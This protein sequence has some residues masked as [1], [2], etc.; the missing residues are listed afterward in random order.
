MPI[1]QHFVDELINVRQIQHG[2]GRGA[3]PIQN[4][5]RVG[6]SINRSCIVMLSA[7]LQAH[8]EEVFQG[9]VRR[10]FP[11]FVADPVAFDRYWK[12][13]KNWGNP[14][15]GN[16][17]I[18]FLKLGVPDIL[19]GLSWQATTQPT[20]LSKLNKLNQIRNKIAHGAAHLTVDDQPYSLDLAKVTAF[21]NFAQN[22]GQRFEPHV[23]NVI[24]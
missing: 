13:M 3:P 6:A 17:K 20:V 8:V 1:N 10:R 16:I 24:P 22:F 9:A 23:H 7:L 21:R 5:Q 11:D 19:A 18:L 4:G 2:G 12:Q 15:D 14:S